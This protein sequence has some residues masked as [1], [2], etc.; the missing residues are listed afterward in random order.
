MMKFGT[1]T[2]EDPGDVDSIRNTYY[3]NIFIVLL[4][5][6]FMVLTLIRAIS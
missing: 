6:I 4:V 3:L 1:L 2:E 5:F